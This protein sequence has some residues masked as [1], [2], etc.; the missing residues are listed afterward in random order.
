M[1]PRA[2][3]FDIGNVVVRWSPATLYDKIFPDPAARDRFLSTVCTMEWH[4]EVDRGLSFRDNIARLTAL[5]PD[6]APEIAAW[7]DRWPEM[8]SGTIPETEAA[9]EALHAAGVPLY[10]LTNMSREAWPGVRAMSGVF[11][12]FK[13]TVVSAEE[14]VVKPDPEIFKIAVQRI[15][16]EPSALLFVDDSEANIRA[17]EAMGFHTHHF[18]DPAALRPA[19]RA[20]GL[21]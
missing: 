2:V 18:S 19:L 15:G 1:R 11:A 7:W 14:G 12:L 16:L 17:A 3:L 20:F 21:L 9:I 6:H 5:H 4:V 10:G 8:F 13:D